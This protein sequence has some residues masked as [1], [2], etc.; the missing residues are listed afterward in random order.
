MRILFALSF[1]TLT[2]TCGV[3]GPPTPPQ[4]KTPGVS[5]TGEAALGVTGAL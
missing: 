4:A 1:L 2:A 5:V 3:D